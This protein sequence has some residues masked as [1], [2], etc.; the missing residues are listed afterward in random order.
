MLVV[1]EAGDFALAIVKPGEHG[2][3]GKNNVSTGFL[4]VHIL[5]LYLKH[6]SLN[7]LYVG[8]SRSCHFA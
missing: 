5:D 4:L 7:A 2:K 6:D 3:H 1:G 8:L